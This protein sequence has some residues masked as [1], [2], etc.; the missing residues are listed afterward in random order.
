MQLH[1]T[2]LVSPPLPTPVC[3]RSVNLAAGM[4]LQI[5]ILEILLLEIHLILSSPTQATIV[6]IE[7][8]TDIE[9]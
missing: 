7:I 3:L 9:T 8:A 2:H 5:L 1:D 4:I 6:R